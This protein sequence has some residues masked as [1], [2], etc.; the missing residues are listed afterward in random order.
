MV[1]IRQDF[2]ISRRKEPRIRSTKR[3]P[4][5]KETK[6]Y[7]L[8]SNPYESPL[9]LIG[10]LFSLYV[11][12]S[13][14]SVRMLTSVLSFSSA[15]AASRFSLLAISSLTLLSGGG[16]RGS[17]LVGENLSLDSSLL[18]CSFVACTRSCFWFAS[19]GSLRWL[20]RPSR[21][22]ARIACGSTW[23]ESK[24]TSKK[25]SCKT[26]RGPRR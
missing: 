26:R 21:S 3:D 7:N 8:E 14:S 4:R 10:N 25:S 2:T 20:Q 22:L 13:S 11:N 18:R 6:K 1:T 19:G 17:Y 23:N 24:R 12:F 15:S 16:L 9:L 5:E